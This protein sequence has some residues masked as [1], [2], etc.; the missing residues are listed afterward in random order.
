MQIEELAANNAGE[1]AQLMYGM[2]PEWWPS[3]ED[4][5]RQLT[6]IEESIGTVG[7]VLA[8][9][10]G[11]PVGWT[12][13]RELKGYLS[14]ELECCGYNDGGV[15]Q[16]EHKLKPLFDKAAEYAKEKGYTTLRTG[17]SSV[18]FTCDGLPL[19]DIPQA[20]QNLKTDRVDY[21]WLLEYGFRVIGISPNA[22]GENH[23]LILFAKAL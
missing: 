10:A 15:F 1:V 21:H 13:F 14:L 12:L 19:D 4:A 9:E 11:K 5:F 20:I 7:W 22:Y 17:M 2:K 23:H 6:E 16:L 3:E 8:D 18:D